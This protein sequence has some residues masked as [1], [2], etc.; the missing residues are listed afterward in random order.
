MDFL[1]ENFQTVLQNPTFTYL[2]SATQSHLVSKLTHLRTMVVQPYLIEQLS[3]F[4]ASYS[5]SAPDLL[6]IFLLAIILF[7]SLKLL[8]YAYRIVMFWVTL[9]FR[10]VFWGS[11]IALGY[12][13]YNAGPEKAYQD[14]GW[15]WGLLYGFVDDFQEKGKTA[16]AAY[17]A[18]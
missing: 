8:G 2:Q 6:T 18:N 14:F 11:I 16:A 1:P 13:V 9:V 4:M 12:H 10:L 7:L 17:V 15:L 3:E 5:A